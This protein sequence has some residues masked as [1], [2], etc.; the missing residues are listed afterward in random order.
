MAAWVLGLSR[1][2]MGGGVTTW[3][4]SH[5]LCLTLISPFLFFL[6]FIFLFLFYFF[7]PSFLAFPFGFEVYYCAGFSSFF[8][9]SLLYIYIYFK[10]FMGS[11]KILGLR[12]GIGMIEVGGWA[13]TQGGPELKTKGLK[14]FFLKKIY[15]LKKK[16]FGPRG[17][18]GPLRPLPRSVTAL[19]AL[20]RLTGKYGHPEER[21]KNETWRLLR[22][23]W[24]RASLLWVCINDFN[25]ILCSEERNGQIPRSLQPMQDFQSTLLHCGLVD[26]GFQGNRYTWR[27]G[28]HED[29]FVEQQLDR[30]CAL[31]DWRD[32]YPQTKV[33]HTSATYSDHDPI[34]LNTELTLTRHWPRMKIQRFE[35]RWVAHPECEDRIRSSWV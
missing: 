26:L 10:V 23:L 12:A 32:L 21:L 7:F 28:R 24:A 19:H 14:P 18:P 1:V 16:N 20:W 13:K 9:F 8:F 4:V 6:F 11:W 27:N 34:L 17:G 29:A 22:H 3:W 33:F 5:F 31:E 15:I 35:E 30:A 2:G 25:E